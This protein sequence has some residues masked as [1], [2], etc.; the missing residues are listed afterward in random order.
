MFDHSGAT[1]SPPLNYHLQPEQFC[2]II[3]GLASHDAEHVGFDTSLFKMGLTRDYGRKRLSAGRDSRKSSTR[4]SPRST[5]WRISSDVGLFFFAAFMQR[6]R[7]PCVIKDSWV[8]VGELQGKESE[9]YLLAHARSYGVSKGI[10]MI[11]HSEEVHVKGE[12][13]NM[14]P[15]TVLNNRHTASVANSKDERSHTRLILTPYGMP[16]DKFSN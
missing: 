14:R 5:I 12:A 3:S 11:Q 13:G 9:A 10:P 16:L 7:K 8:S 15:D 1:S 2:A 6:E 4:S